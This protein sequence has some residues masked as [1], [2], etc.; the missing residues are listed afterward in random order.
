MAA[1]FVCACGHAP[2]GP[3]RREHAAF[4][5]A[6]CKPR[7][8][9]P[10][11]R[12]GPVPWARWRAKA[13]F[14]SS[15]DPRLASLNAR[16]LAAY[17]CSVTMRS[18]HRKRSRKLNSQGAPTRPNLCSTCRDEARGGHVSEDAP[19][20]PQGRNPATLPILHCAVKLLS[21][22]QCAACQPRGP[23]Q[24]PL[25]PCNAT[26]SPSQPPCCPATR[27][28][29]Q[30]EASTGKGELGTGQGDSRPPTEPL[31]PN[32][33]PTQP[34]PR[35]WAGR[36]LRAAARG[37]RKQ[38]CSRRLPHGPTQARSEARRALRQT[39]R[40]RAHT[41]LRTA[42]TRPRLTRPSLE[43]GL[44]RPPRRPATGWCDGPPHQCACAQQGASTPGPVGETASSGAKG[45][46]P[47]ATQ[48]TAG[49]KGQACEVE[50]R[51][52][53]KGRVGSDRG[54]T[55][56][57]QARSTAHEASPPRTPVPPAPGRL[58]AR[59]SGLSRPS[60]SLARAT[61]PQVRPRAGPLL[62]AA[63]RR[64]QSGA[65]SRVEPRAAMQGATCARSPR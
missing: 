45:A 9:A 28:N 46:C 63:G 14:P 60:V 16:G 53:C 27:A 38:L 25:T 55:T 56:R 10:R 61:G 8:P 57:G 12:A 13:H 15:P 33:F 44:H 26:N 47:L 34:P 11:P 40:L 29:R 43:R 64:R 52:N 36:R 5:G 49:E 32:P 37:N 22:F 48:G 23:A 51:G 20:H 3:V 35:Q 6:C 1:V 54:P 58:S 59:G 7:R 39:S 21:W 42:A 41:Q 24:P 30:T 19:L 62:R 17:L 2:S 50:P 65:G 4:K 18:H 31:N